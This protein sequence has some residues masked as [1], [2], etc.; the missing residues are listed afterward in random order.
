MIEK[1][2]YSC[3]GVNVEAQRRDPGSLLSWTV[4]MIRVRKECPEIGWGDWKVLPTRSPSLLVM[5]YDW[6]GN[7]LITIHNFDDKPHEARIKL[8]P[9]GDRLVNLLIEDESEADGNGTHRIAIEGYG[10]HWYRIGGLNHILR[11]E[12]V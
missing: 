11:R 3:A 12:K 8:G 10:Y 7:A 6:R 4:D 9:G 2:P 5:R 1:G